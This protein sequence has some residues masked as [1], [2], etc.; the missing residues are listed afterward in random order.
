M[1]KP[2]YKKKAEVLSDFQVVLREQRKIS[3]AIWRYNDLQLNGTIPENQDEKTIIEEYETAI[4]RQSFYLEKMPDIYKECERLNLSY[5]KRKIRLHK[6]IE[7]MCQN[8]DCIF[9]T[10]TFNDDAL[11]RTSQATRRQKITRFLKQFNVPYV[12]NIDYGKKNH[13]EHYHAV[14]QAEKIDYKAYYD[15]NLGTINGQVIKNSAVDKIRVSKYVAK[16]TNHAIKETTKRSCVIY[17]KVS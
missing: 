6:R 1:S 16:L 5:Y 8:G 3:Y 2:D 7:N 9:L 11:K 4:K 13:R 17:G 14:I 12:A 10:L 15:L